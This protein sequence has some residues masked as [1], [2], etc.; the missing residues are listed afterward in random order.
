VNLL[1]FAFSCVIHSLNYPES[2]KLK[3]LPA[4]M[5]PSF[6]ISYNYS[7]CRI[8][9]IPADFFNS[10]E[11]NYLIRGIT[12]QNMFGRF[13]LQVQMKTSLEVLNM[14]HWMPLT[15]SM[16]TAHCWFSKIRNFIEI[17]SIKIHCKTLKY[18][19][20]EFKIKFFCFNRNVKNVNNALPLRLN[21]TLKYAIDY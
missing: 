16:I 1:I 12:N 19:F 10:S 7:V 15:L 2:N 6:V 17:S 18:L 13:L 4:E 20:N 5:T 14:N 11:N 3:N 21:T 8:S 9:S